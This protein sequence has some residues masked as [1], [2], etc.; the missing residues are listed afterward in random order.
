M[1][2]EKIIGLFT[3]GTVQGGTENKTV[4]HDIV[5]TFPY[6]QLAQVLYARHLYDDNDTD[7]TSRMKLAATYA[8]N[9]KA[10]YM[11][12]RK[13][14]E[15]KKETLE[16][17]IAVPVKEEVKYNFVYKSSEETVVPKVEAKAEVVE[18]IVE[19]VIEEQPKKE[20]KKLSPVSETFLEKEILSTIA[21][22]QTE[23]LVED[24]A[25][26]EEITPHE[27]KVI[28][29]EHR[30]HHVTAGEMHSFDEWLKLLP[31]VEG[32][33]V[34]NKTV[35]P[36]KATDLINSFL[37]NEPRISKPKTEFFSP[38]KAAKLS[39]TEDDELVSETLAKIY[40][41]QGNLHKALKAYE[42]LLLQN[43]EKKAYFAAR[44][45]EIR[46]LIVLGNTK[47]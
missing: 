9:R 4:L 26:E 7:V 1:D 44:I 37:A 47:K 8:P 12:F 43:P 14:L 24:I 32:K 28:A 15:N 31:E 34:E 30:K 38:T 40:A 46:G 41:Q 10:M 3:S 35:T 16:V 17:K 25:K 42:S 23:K 33:H 6:F 13:P 29:P 22:S 45:K 27:H 36:K 20:E 18:K 11:L 21:I 5:Q 19:P 2:K 39:I